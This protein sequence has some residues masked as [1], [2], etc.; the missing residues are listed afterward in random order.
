M[1]RV[2][3]W[4]VLLVAVGAVVLVAGVAVPRLTSDSEALTEADRAYFEVCRA[5]G[6]TPRLAPGSG[7]YVRDQRFCEITYGGRSYEMY[8]ARPS[9]WDAAQ[10]ARARRTCRSQAEDAER[11]RLGRRYVWHERSGICESAAA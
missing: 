7:D 3:S 2:L 1:R 10:V 5:H 9:G 6:G 8:A 4:P 11:E